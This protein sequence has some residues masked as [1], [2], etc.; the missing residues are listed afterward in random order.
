MS[1]R[2]QTM[3]AIIKGFA[4]KLPKF[5]DGRIDYSDSDTAPV[6]IVFVKYQ[7]KI[8]L[9]KR[10]NKVRAYR[11]KWNTV[12]GYLDELKPLR[13]K[14]LEEVQEELGINE[15]NILLFRIGESYEFTDVEVNKTWI[16]NPCLIELKDEPVIKLDWEHTEYKWIKPE[17]LREFDV[18]SKLDTSLENISK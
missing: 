16:V 12:A 2:E 18:V 9:L 17:E 5:P 8:L 4:D 3:L 14:A 10:S 11:G 15:D 1:K 13:E 7:D 6:I